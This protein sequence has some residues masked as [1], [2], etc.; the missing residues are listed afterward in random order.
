MN[1]AVLAPAWLAWLFVALLVLAA[2]EDIWRLRISNL[3]CI[4]IILAAFA[5]A[6]AAGPRPALWQNLAIFIGLLAIGTPIFAA[7]KLGGGDVKLF[8]AAGLWFALSGGL[9]FL[10]LSLLAGGLLAIIIIMIRLFPW[11]AGARQRIVTLR[12]HG[13]IPYGVAISAG[14][15]LTV[16]LLRR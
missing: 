13:G 4:A 11:S 10:I 5:A 14:A 2:A 6:A 3:T 15:L 12:R 8:A 1:L 16:A 9:R 7:G